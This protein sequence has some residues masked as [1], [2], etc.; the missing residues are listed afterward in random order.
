MCI[1]QG[2]ILIRVYSYI[3][4][5]LIKCHFIHL[6]IL[7]VDSS[8]YFDGVYISWA[9]LV[10][11]LCAAG[12]TAGK[13]LAEKGVNDFLILEGQSIIGGR[14][15][16]EKFGGVSVEKGA[17]WVEGV[18]GPEL[19]P[20]LPLVQELGLKNARSDYSN[21]TSNI[22]MAGYMTPQVRSCMHLQYAK[23]CICITRIVK[24]E[25]LHWCEP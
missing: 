2:L 15:H 22:Y 21:V 7:V 13:R 24:I 14:M 23:Y 8:C 18:N 3:V 9:F 19:N 17:N 11:D 10:T 6:L 1:H 5:I 20:I 16:K 4:R 12:I 25:F